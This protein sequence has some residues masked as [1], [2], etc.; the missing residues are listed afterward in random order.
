MRDL[1]RLN[2]TALD[3]RALHKQAKRVYVKNGAFELKVGEMQYFNMN[4]CQGA[5]HG[6][7]PLLAVAFTVSTVDK[8]SALKSKLLT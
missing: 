2:S 6:I 1:S 3:K 4:L 5:K 8:T 7:K